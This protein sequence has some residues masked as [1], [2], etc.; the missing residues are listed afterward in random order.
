MALFSH[1]LAI[2][3][4]AANTAIF[5]DE[6]VALDEPRI[7]A[8]ETKTGQLVAIRYA[9]L[10]C[11]LLFIS[12][13]DLRRG[14][15]K[16]PSKITPERYEHIKCNSVYYWKT[17]FKLDSVENDFLKKH[18][19]G[20]IYLRLFDV[21]EDYD[22][23]NGTCSV[24]PVG[25]ISFES[26]VPEGMEIVPTVFITCRALQ[27]ACYEY[28]TD[29]F[30]DILLT[31]MLK[32]ASYN[33]LDPVREIQL[34]CDWTQGNKEMFYELCR[35]VRR[36]LEPHK[37][38]LSVTVRLHQLVQDPPPADRAVL[39]L[40]NTGS[41]RQPGARNSIL[42]EKDVASYLKKGRRIEY[43][44]PLDFAWPAYSWGIL[45]RGG[46]FLSLLHTTDYSD[47]A[48]YSF[49]NERTVRVKAD[50]Y[51]EGHQLLAGDYIRLEIPKFETIRAVASMV[52]ESFPEV[53]HGNIL[54]HLDSCNISNYSYDEIQTLFGF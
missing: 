8:V 11:A 48:L 41:F 24:V 29:R 19:I 50:H 51:L 34:D 26:L 20:R 13:C 30:A 33:D 10:L 17:V 3:M 40:Y 44:L 52:K 2:D 1:E 45:F 42:D 49:E 16:E 32:M 25:S 6:E 23:I 14:S 15:I 39:M 46:K 43:G 54:Y 36:K 27:R 28:G 18:D 22:M 9:A 53:D 5:K 21:D 47:R 31:R 4:G 37:I 12:S 35:T 7:I 38:L